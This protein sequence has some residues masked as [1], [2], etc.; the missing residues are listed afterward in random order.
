MDDPGRLADFAANLTSADGTE[1]QR[2]L[3]TFDVRKRIDMVLV[4]LKKELEVSRL[5]SKISKSIEEK[6]S[7]RSANFSCANSSRRSRR[8]SAWKRRERP[9]SWRS[10]RTASRNSSLTARRS[11]RWMRR[12]RNCH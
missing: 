11:G 7:A 8:N 3:E 12:W 2:I 4:L 6:V 5:Q 10:S 9:P 1:L